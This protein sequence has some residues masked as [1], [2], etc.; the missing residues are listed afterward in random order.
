[1]ASPGGWPDDYRIPDLVLLTPERFQIDRDEYFDGAPT[2]VVEIRSRGDETIEKLPFYAKIG[3]PE[4][5]IIDRDTKTPEIHVLRGSPV[6]SSDPRRGRLAH[7]PGHGR[8]VAQGA[9]EE[10]REYGWPTIPA[11]PNAC[12]RCEHYACGIGKDHRVWA[13]LTPFSTRLSGVGN[14]LQYIWDA[15][16]GT[17]WGRLA[18]TVLITSLFLA[19]A[20]RQGGAINFGF[21]V[22]FLAIVL[23]CALYLEFMSHRRPLDKAGRIQTTWG[24]V[25]VMI[26]F[27]AFLA[28]LVCCIIVVL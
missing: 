14:V 9:E 7:Q 6:R 27:L 25:L 1:M 22:G 13:R 16:K 26:L 12:L 19:C 10:T 20:L 23:V 24:D 11:P 21:F 17:I 18:A 4:V 15:L 8:S 3:V 5:W 2:V 28:G